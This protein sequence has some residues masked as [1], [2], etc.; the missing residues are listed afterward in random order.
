VMIVIGLPTDL[1]IRETYRTIYGDLA[2]KSRVLF[3]R[4]SVQSLR[5]E[6]RTVATIG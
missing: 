6:K 1:P 2:V 4:P 3:M 5:A